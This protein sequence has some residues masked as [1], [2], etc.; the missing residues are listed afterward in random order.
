MKDVLVVDIPADLDICEVAWL[1]DAMVNLKVVRIFQQGLPGRSDVDCY[2]HYSVFKTPTVVLL[3]MKFSGRLTEDKDSGTWE[4]CSSTDASAVEGEKLI[5]VV[6]SSPS[7]GPVFTR[8]HY[9]WD[10]HDDSPFEEVVYYFKDAEALDIS[11]LSKDKTATRRW[12]ELI[13]EVGV[14]ALWQTPVRLVNFP[15][16]V[17]FKKSDFPRK[18]RW[19]KPTKVFKVL[20]K[21]VAEEMGFDD[22]DEGFPETPL[23]FLTASEYE[24]EVGRETVELEIG[25]Q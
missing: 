10:C 17:T 9:D 15:N 18:G 7:T 2:E 23:R 3:P 22:E 1:G 12:K 6:Y 5:S 20:V 8:H 24:D 13:E 25:A 4:P 19:R 16:N 21:N 11:S 14:Y